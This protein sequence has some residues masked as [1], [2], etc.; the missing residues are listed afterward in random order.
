MLISIHLHH[1]FEMQTVYEEVPNIEENTAQEKKHLWY[2]PHKDKNIQLF[3]KR[4]SK[5]HY[6]LLQLCEFTFSKLHNYTESKIRSL[7]AQ[8]E[9]RRAISRLEPQM[10]VRATKSEAHPSH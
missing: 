9:L 2:L 5:C 7:E 6:C 1:L 3:L 4:T 8:A 10:E